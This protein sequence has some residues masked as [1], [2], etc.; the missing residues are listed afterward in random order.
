MFVCRDYRFRIISLHVQNAYRIL[1]IALGLRSTRSSGRQVIALFKLLK[2][3]VKVNG[4][5]HIALS[6]GV[7]VIEYCIAVVHAVGG[8]SVLTR[9]RRPRHPRHAA[10]PTAS[11]LALDTATP[12]QNLPTHYRN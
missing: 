1:L 3:Y 2:V 4:T 11:E 9:S 5:Y 7:V 8:A 10:G 12:T 6:F